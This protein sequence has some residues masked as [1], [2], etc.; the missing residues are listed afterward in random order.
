MASRYAE[1]SKR[2]GMFGDGISIPDIVI[3]KALIE[4]ALID[5]DELAFEVLMKVKRFGD[6]RSETLDNDRNVLQLIDDSWIQ[7]TRRFLV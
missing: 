3:A 1:T 6:P 5:N 4:K 7:L 2:V